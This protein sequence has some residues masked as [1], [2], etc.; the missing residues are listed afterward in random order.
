MTEQ[1]AAPTPEWMRQHEGGWEGPHR[2]QTTYKRTYQKR[3]VVDVLRSR[4]VINTDQAFVADQLETY[5]H[6]CRNGIGLVSSYGNQ[7]WSGTTAGQEDGSKLTIEWPIYCSQKLA[8]AERIVGRPVSWRVMQLVIH[9]NNTLT[10]TARAIGTHRN[11]VAEMVISGL[12][13]IADSDYCAY[14]P[15]R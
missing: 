9:E 5:W 3:K 4:R 13:S 8:Q 12:Q 7:R 11:D 6:G 2:D 10:Q 14:R 1:I 15:R